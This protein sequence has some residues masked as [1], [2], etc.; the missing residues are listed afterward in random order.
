M[1]KAKSPPP[2]DLNYSLAASPTAA[3]TAPLL[4][5]EPPTPTE[6]Q[7]RIGLIACGGITETHL[8]AYRKVGWNVVGLCDLIAERAETRRR[9]FYP[10][11]FTTTDYRELLKHDEIDVVDIATHP[12][13][14]AP[15][16]SDAL[17][18]HKHVLSQKPFVL[19]LAT[20]RELVE[21]A[22][23]VDRRLAVNQNGRYA[24]HFS[25][26][27]K[28]V[29]A[30]LVGDVTGVHMA[31]HWD[32]SWTAGTPFERIRDLV[33]YDFAIHWFDMAMQL[34]DG[35][36]WTRVYGERTCAARQ[37]VKPPL[38]ASAAFQY[39]GGHGTLVFDGNVQFGPA[40]STYVAGTLGSLC[41]TGPNLSRQKVVLTTSAGV[42]SPQ[43]HGD[44]FPDGFRGTMGE[45]LCAIEEGREPA[46]SA[47]ANLRSLE[48]CF[49]AIASADDGLPKLA[50][51]VS[52]LPT[53]SAP[54]A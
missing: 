21:L 26:M 44:W 51:E 52:R 28:A 3:T 30:G 31:V 14:R 23:S 7:P 19:D 54:G 37:P 45:L 42:A 53:G 32:H 8:K 24:P 47:A 49:A 39:D 18:A 6:Y 36:A 25:Y 27:R 15:I 22:R 1:K 2:D 34:L 40:D 11:A 17:R 16:I 29:E 13:D 50:G 46:N 33:L 35:R 38:L 10:D 43:L 41:S 4:P 20:G 9:Q 48:L 12:Q 5:W